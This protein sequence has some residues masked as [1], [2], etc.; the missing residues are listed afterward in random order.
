MGGK[1]VRIVSDGTPIGTKVYDADGRLMDM[2]AITKVEWSIEA[3]G[4]GV[5]RLTLANVEVDL[6]GGVRE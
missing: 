1:R 6:I 2:G 5:A 3:A 4:T